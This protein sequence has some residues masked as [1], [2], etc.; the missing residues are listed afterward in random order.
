MCVG[1]PPAA[2][3]WRGGAAC[4]RRWG[5]VHGHSS[6]PRIR[7]A[8]HPGAGSPPGAPRASP[9][10]RAWT[11][12]PAGTTLSG[13]SYEVLWINSAESQSLAN[14]GWSFEDACRC[15]QS[16]KLRGCRES[17][18]VRFN[19]VFALTNVRFHLF[20]YCKKLLNINHRKFH[21]DGQL[22]LR[23]I[24]R[25]A[26]TLVQIHWEMEGEGLLILFYDTFEL[27]IGLSAAGMVLCNVRQGWPIRVLT[28]KA[29][30]FCIRGLAPWGRVGSIVHGA[31]GEACVAEQRWRDG[32]RRWAG[33]LPGPRRGAGGVGTARG[34]TA[35]RSVGGGGGGSDSVRFSG[36]WR[37]N[38]PAPQRAQ[39]M[40]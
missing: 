8:A 1:A 39:G 21:T 30:V 6:G 35:G 3:A 19:Y 29:W 12:S 2:G 26:N 17:Y 31:R 22:A 14:S 23:L 7:A 40:H 34:C 27:C 32:G 20:I 33:Q 4:R 5:T 15:W 38:L 13:S 28:Q 37:A 24:K 18:L 36:G 11:T 25:V 16:W 10:P 9:A